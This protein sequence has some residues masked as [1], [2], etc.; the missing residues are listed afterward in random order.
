MIDFSNPIMLS[1]LR[2]ILCAYT[3][4]DPD[5]GY[6][7]GMGFV[8]AM[9]RVYLDE[10]PAFWCFHNLMNGPVLQMRRLY[11]NRF[12]GLRSLSQV[13]DAALIDKYP[14]VWKCFK[15]ID[16]D[17]MIY[18]TGWFLT[19]F[20]TMNLKAEVRLGL[21]DRFITFG[22][23]ALISFGLVIVSRLKA[24]LLKSASSMDAYQILQRPYE[25]REF[26]DWRYVLAKYDKLWISSKDYSNYFKKAGV[27]LFL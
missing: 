9:F 1:S 3:N 13:W 8:A 6:F 7:Q 22:C 20:M 26:E 12:Q 10:T 18:T 27:E 15:E 5:V 19:G 11:M 2:T 16:V 14:K 25:L 17:S 21:F 23:R 24:L 4:I